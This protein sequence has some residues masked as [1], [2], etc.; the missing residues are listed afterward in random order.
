MAF[1]AVRFAFLPLPAPPMSDASTTPAAD[2]T[3]AE[4]VFEAVL[5]LEPEQ[6]GVFVIIPAEVT[7]ALGTR[8]RVPVEVT[9]D[10][11]PYRGS[12]TPMGDGRHGLLLLKAIRGAIGKTWGDSVRVV[13]RRDEAPRVVA[14]PPDLALA[15]ATTPGARLRF[16]E[17]SYT[18]QKEHVRS[19]EGA[20]KED[21][22][23]R[24]IESIVESVLA[25][26]KRA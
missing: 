21:T 5:E 2:S 25:G 13:L 16:E 15:L 4:Y 3:P 26:K 17:L 8:G 19:V 11:F 6:G 9:F 12:A 20:K 1:F 22:R 14:V 7:A 23:R 18:T 10:G 24:R